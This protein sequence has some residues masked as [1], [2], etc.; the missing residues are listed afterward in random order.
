MKLRFLLLIVFLEVISFAAISQ[1]KHNFKFD[2]LTVKDGLS[3]GNT[4]DL[5]E[6]TF[7]FIW[8]GTE[9]GLN[10]YNGN[11]F[12]IF[13]KKPDDSTSLSNNNIFCITEDPNGN[14]WIGTQNGLNLYDRRLNK[15][16]RFEHDSLNAS[17]LSDNVIYKILLDSKMRLW[18]GTANGLNLYDPLTKGFKHFFHEPSQPNSLP[19]SD[20]Q[21]LIEDRL[22]N[23][24]IATTGGLSVL[25]ADRKTFLNFTHRPDD[26]KS[27]SSNRTITLFED[28][29]NQL[30]VGTFDAGLNRLDRSNGTFTRFTSI[31]NDPT[32]LSDQFVR[33]IG[34]NQQGEL[35]IG[36]DGGL[37]L[38]DREA[39]TFTQVL[40]E[41]S[42]EHG[43]KSSLIT[44]VMFDKNDRMWVGTRYGGLNIYDKG[45]NLFK[46]FKYSRN[47]KTGL[48]GNN[49]SSFA[50]DPFGNIWI[51]VDRGG[52][53]YFDRKKDSFYSITH[54]PDEPNSLS[55]NKVLA[56]EPDKGGGLWL[57]YW[58]TGL[59]YFNP[60]TKV[61]KHFKHDAQNPRS[62]SDNNVFDILR[63]RKGNI[64][65]ATFGN[66]I[67]K[68][69]EAT[70]DF[71][72]YVN[73]SNDNN[74][75][76]GGSIIYLLEDHLGK[77]WIGSRQ[78]GL[79]MFDPE[80]GIFTHYKAADKKGYLSEN[81]IFSL[82]ED[83]QK[84]LWI[85][86]NGGGLNLFDR[87]SQTF[88]VFRERDGLPNDV[89]MGILEDNEHNLWISTSKGLSK[90]NPIRTTF[91]NY[92]E[93][94]G[95][96]SDQ[97]SRWAFLK[98]S[99]GELLFGGTNGF[100]IFNP[101]EIRN[102]PYVP[103]VYITDFKLFNK[104]VHIGEQE[105]L[106][107]NI[108]LT[109]KITLDYD[110]NF[111]SIEFAAL[112]FRQPEK[113][114]YKYILEGLQ[115]EWV[116]AGLE[117]NVNYTNIN[118]GEYTFKVLAS[119]NDGVW[120]MKGAVLRIVITPPFWGTWW[121]RIL[122]VFCFAAVVI[123]YYKIRMNAIHTQKKEL[124]QQ[125]KERT[126]EV[127]QQKEI[128]ESQSE[129]LQKAYS[130]L[131]AQKGEIL[132]REKDAE[133]ARKHAEQ[134]NQAKSIFLAT[135]SHEIRTPMNGVIGMASL[136]SETP[137]TEEQ[138]EYTETIKTCG[139]SL[140][141][142]INDILD[143]SKIESGNMELEHTDF[144][145]RTCIE[146]VLDVFANRASQI[147]L[148]LVYEIDYN[149]PSQLVGDSLRLRQVML[150]LV[151]NAIKFTHK[152]EIFIGVRLLNTIGDQIEL[153]FEIRDTGIGI[154]NEKIDRLFKAFSQVD[155]STTRKYGGT[156]LGL[157]ICEKL[158]ALMKG[159][160]TV[161]SRLGH[162][163]VFTFTIK[164]NESKQ[165]SKTFV[166]HSL[167]ALEGKKALIIDDN[168]TN[169]SILK[170]QLQQWK[171][172]ITLAS[173]GEQALKVLHQSSDFDLILTDMQMPEMDGM[174]LS[175][176]I[177]SLYKNIKIILLSS[178]G[179]ERSKLH[180]EL[181]SAV[182]TKPVKQNILCKHILSQLT[183][184]EYKR[185]EDETTLDRKLTAGFALKFPLNI[186]I[187]DDNPVNQKLAERV[188]TKLGYT[189]AKALNGQEALNSLEQNSFDIILM[190]IQMP[191]MDGLEAT[192]KIR[193]QTK[194]QPVIIAMTANAMAG[195]KET[196]LQAGMDDYISK[197]IKL[198]LVIKML[199]KW[200]LYRNAV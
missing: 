66:G 157:V 17:S 117:R 112:N 177:R 56:I 151:G 116:D 20:I 8:I 113:N 54:D 152:G 28:H 191:V 134:A 143:F 122:T 24:W 13:K 45:K 79:D 10:L 61:F 155:S 136:L 114:Q 97:F 181:F 65:V 185:S 57:G 87:K 144:D 91:K 3:Q 103:P 133:D 21:F 53:N 195:D 31:P 154:S 4:L 42:N 43:L 63:D 14:L 187:A 39:S 132:I 124:E 192:Q 161:E 179:D 50:E 200:Y 199:E 64:W 62:L 84:N 34:E 25:N 106:K 169:R 2:H 95:L 93:G 174:Q 119:N 135:M 88:T 77:I 1:K 146:E 107:Q 90:F 55:G 58:K 126:S 197:P 150:N 27:L 159:S 9:D 102:N 80:T 127:V 148:D 158:V 47:D 137:Q 188:L 60:K 37:N 164:T 96:Q 38:L 19:N 163:T 23:I 105:L 125:V 189:P 16:Q 173:S 162:G 175:Q 98:L 44:K 170:N 140:L 33:S 59:D 115:T 83:T 190:D 41:E 141:T 186:L 194:D 48:N 86:T 76:T 101:T 120:N 139:E 6:D 5:F 89:I 128:L 32:S 74:S 123:T 121:F 145:L 11:Q 29:N 118:P 183:G 92:Y 99:T 138:K 147:G 35:W 104:S 184:Q 40:A 26:A 198:D 109:D 110:E 46:H 18:V 71:T 67:N 153:G 78:Q 51:G 168:T 130:E 68:F 52:L 100:N 167:T 82:Y 129:F 7:G 193:R 131:L 166:H 85:G 149:V 81:S 70:G 108:M 49:V 171:M 94:D 182:L 180:T 69:N 160:V 165:S 73:N 15:F 75:I 176:Q 142:V 72:R 36:T 156:G 22:Q 178:I 30:W 111:F 12:T 172:V 196:C